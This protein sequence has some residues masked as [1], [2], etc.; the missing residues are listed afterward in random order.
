LLHPELDALASSGPH[1]A[2]CDNP[3]HTAGPH[4]LA[5]VIYTSG[6]TGNP[7]GVA[8]P[9]VAVTR[10]VLGTDYVQLGPDDVVAQASNHSFDAATFEIWGALLNGAQL[11]FVPHDD[12]LCPT[13][14]EQRIVETGIN[15]MFLTTA[16]FNEHSARSPAMFRHLDHLLFGGESADLAAVRRVLTA[17]APR[18]LL[19]VYGPT[20]T[21]TFA[22]WHP[23]AE[24]DTTIPIGR[25]IANT[26]CRVLDAQRQLTPPGVVG[27]L[28]IGG[29]GVAR[30]Y[31]NRPELSAERFVADPFRPAERLYRTGDLV[32][33]RRDG[34]LEYL[35][36]ADRQ[37]K[38]RGFRI[39]LGEVEAAL[40]RLPAVA[41]AVV[42]LQDAPSGD[43][44]LVAY[45]VPAG[46]SDAMGQ[47]HL[48]QQLAAMLPPYMVPSVVVALTAM[49]LTPNG[50]V[51]RAALPRPEQGQAT[52]QTDEDDEL[53]Q[54]LKAEWMQVLG[55]PTLSVDDS[56]FDL[57]GHSLLA[58]RLLDAVERRFGRKLALASL[59]D[60]PTVRR[61]AALLHSAETSSSGCVVTVQPEGERAPL[62]FVS[63]FGGAILP[64]HA[65]SRHLGTEQPLHVL[66]I[67]SLRCLA[68]RSPTLEEMAREMMADMRRLQ[69]QGPYRLAG[70]SLG[71]KIVYA[72]AQ[73]LLAEGEAVAL[74]ALLDCAAPGFP[75][76]LP[77]LTRVGAHLRHA[78]AKDPGDAAAYVVQRIRR[79][80]K[81]VGVDNTVEPTVFKSHQ[82][83]DRSATLVRDIES[84]AKPVYDAWSAY[85]PG[86][87]AGRITLIRAL[88]RTI[89]PGVDDSDPKMGWERL[90]AGGVD[91]ATLDCE[92]VAMLDAEHAPALARVLGSLV[93]PACQIGER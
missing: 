53:L 92:H 5:Y 35:G 22:T 3:I 82:M 64:F 51:D 52:G 86:P 32:R 25:P 78:F 26:V 58:I 15:T 60:G 37:I 12:L 73:Q 30:G 88:R 46:D 43:K 75:R 63:G 93:E 67:N 81:Y 87:Y 33:Y 76:L 91:V 7:K 77:F 65:L 68:N 50:K 61:Q 23:I 85:E 27:E 8:V 90:A 29:V 36:R 45:V 70:F 2:S 6:S 21:T 55:V 89:E 44:R 79:L 41:Q 54:Q 34:S 62:F 19:N 40:C 80:S 11:A 17:G 16:L 14:L 71:G 24:S 84:R 28:F 74:L 49:P 4:H 56:F 13:A 38:L 20:E 59:F 83:V 47:V 57:G 10:L 18:R 66:D 72:M 31:L 39:E 42:D 9:Q 1:T 48:Q 69:P